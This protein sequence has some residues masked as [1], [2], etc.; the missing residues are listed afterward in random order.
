MN[1]KDEAKW[2]IAEKKYLIE[3]S[4]EILINLMEKKTCN[5]KKRTQ[6]KKVYDKL[7]K[8]IILK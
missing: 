6:S 7:F 3:D 1:F 5:K 8:V 2:P 4:K